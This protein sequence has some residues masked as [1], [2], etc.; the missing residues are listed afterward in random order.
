MPKRRETLDDLL[1]SLVP[2]ERLDAFAVRAGIS[3]AGLFNLRHGQT[4]KPQRRT[5]AAI[6]AALGVDLERVRKAIEESMRVHG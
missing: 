3:P 5:V 6:A 2:N 4:A 1:G